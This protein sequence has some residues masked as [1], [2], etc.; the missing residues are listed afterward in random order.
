MAFRSFSCG[1]TSE[2]AEVQ[3]DV[4]PDFAATGTGQLAQ[5]NEGLE[6]FYNI[7]FTTLL[8]CR[9]PLES[10]TRTGKA[11]GACR[12]PSGGPGVIKP[13]TVSNDI[14]SHHDMLP[15]L[16]TA[17]GEPDIVEKVKEGH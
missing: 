4:A 16:L 12:A 6:P 2:S 8:T 15:T 14:F 13:G 3:G 5:R 17:A 10:R 9:L 7:G 11:L 1:R